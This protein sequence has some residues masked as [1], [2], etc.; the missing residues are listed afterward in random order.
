M[1]IPPP[2]PPD[3]YLALSLFRRGHLSTAAA[4][5]ILIATVTH[6]LA[7]DSTSTASVRAVRSS[8]RGLAGVVPCNLHS[9]TY[10]PSA[11][12]AVW[13]SN[14]GVWAAKNVS[15]EA[16]CRLL[17][18]LVPDAELWL[19]QLEVWMSPDGGRRRRRHRRRASTAAAGVNGL[20]RTF[21]WSTT[22]AATA[23][24]IGWRSSPWSAACGIPCLAVTEASW[25]TSRTCCSPLRMTRLTSSARIVQR[26]T[27]LI[28][29]RRCIMQVVDLARTVSFLA[30]TC[31]DIS[32]FALPFTGCYSFL[33]E[34]LFMGY[35][36]SCPMLR[37]FLSCC[38]YLFLA[39]II[40]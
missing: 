39:L 32:C 9:T 2:S 13:T 10:Q 16:F 25:W 15:S 1:Y 11:H 4:S 20:F 19:A 22:A 23:A 17:Q 8:S 27:S 18:P 21:C 33:P 24:T 40:R 31:S 6:G 28:W 34:A 3:T 29:G 37:P 30:V 14:A 36:V 5:I 38:V 7:A 26:R 35:I 12:K